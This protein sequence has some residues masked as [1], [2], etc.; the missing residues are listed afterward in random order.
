MNFSF[1]LNTP[2]QNP[3]HALTLRLLFEQT[4]EGCRYR[5]REVHAFA[6]HGMGEAQ[7]IGMQTEAMQRVVAIAIFD[8]AADWMAHVGRM[9]TYL[10]LASG[11]KLVFNKRVLGSAV[12]NMVV[13]HRIFATVVYW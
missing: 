10:V 2:M 8:V 13:G 7:H 12:E 9:Y 11:F 5:R 1:L 3:C 4:T 6:R